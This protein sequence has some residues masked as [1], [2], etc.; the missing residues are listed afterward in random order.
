MW[1]I[2]SIANPNPVLATNTLYNI[3]ILIS[4]LLEE[5]IKS[6]FSSLPPAAF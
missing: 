6:D 4:Y 2:N 3:Q 1:L 5:I